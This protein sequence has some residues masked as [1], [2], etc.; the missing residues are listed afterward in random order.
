MGFL[1][2]CE[3]AAEVLPRHQKNGRFSH[4]CRRSVYGII[5]VNTGRISTEVVPFGEVEV[6][7]S[8]WGVKARHTASMHIGKRNTCASAA[9]MTDNGRPGRFVTARQGC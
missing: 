8:S 9:S 4:S 1:V 2:E 5:G 3:L 7:E 6:K